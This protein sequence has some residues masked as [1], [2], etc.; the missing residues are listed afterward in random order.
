MDLTIQ[1]EL[2]FLWLI[3]ILNSFDWYRGMS[4]FETLPDQK[5]CKE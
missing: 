1:P 3:L 2:N 4:I 5:K